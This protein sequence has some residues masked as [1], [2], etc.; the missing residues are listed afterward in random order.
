VNLVTPLPIMT[1]QMNVNGNNLLTVNGASLASTAYG[2][3]ITST[4]LTRSTISGVTFQKFGGPGIDL[5]AARNIS[6]SGV[7]VTD[8]GLGFRASG[9]L[10]GSGVFG[11][12]FTNN[13]IGG[14]LA[15]AQNLLVGVNP[16]GS[17]LQGNTFNGGTGGFRG[18]ST[19]GIS[20]S[21]TSNGTFAK[22][23]TFTGY[24][25]AIY[26][27]AATNATIGGLGVGEGNLI[28]YAKT[29]GVYASGFC[30]GSQVIKTAF[31]TG[32]ASTSQYVISTSRNLVI[33][34]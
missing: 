19:T 9:N 23:N 20:V 32:V 11:S 5:V 1:V 24:P 22:A 29:A 12:T 18:A 4:S 30:T 26:L 2:F 6:V 7:T 14:Q 25:I 13:V 15:N 3:Q 31:G 17:V 8:S 27:A 34:R 10:A 28:S 33:V 21:G 16:V